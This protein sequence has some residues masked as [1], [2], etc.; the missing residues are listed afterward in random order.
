MAETVTVACK[1]PHGLILRV[2]DKVKVQE[3]MPGGGTKGVDR[4]MPRPETVTL[5]GYLE[6]YDPSLPPAARGS[7]YALT[8]GVD[9]DFFELWLKQNHDLDAVVNHLVF[10]HDQDTAGMAEEY[11]NTRSGLEPVDPTKLKGRVTTADE[12]KKTFG[13]PA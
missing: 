3:P 12:Q 1:M 5:K 10:A 7:S 9:K 6:K 2:F 11:R 8:Y 4:A 13:I